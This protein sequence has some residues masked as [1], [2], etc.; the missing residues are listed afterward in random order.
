[1]MRTVIIHLML[2]GMILFTIFL[3]WYNWKMWTMVPTCREGWTAVITTDRG[4]ICLPKG[5][6]KDAE[7]R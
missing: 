1:M 4:E 7:S 2:C 3:G 6:P 5:H